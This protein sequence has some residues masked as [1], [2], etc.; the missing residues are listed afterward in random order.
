MEMST[1]GAGPAGCLSAVEKGTELAT[2]LNKSRISS[3]RK[4]D[5]G[6]RR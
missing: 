5:R 3:G 1:R 4:R 6:A 2:R